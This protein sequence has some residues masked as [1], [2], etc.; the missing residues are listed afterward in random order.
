[1]E[2]TPR[3]QTIST[4]LQRI[5]EQARNYPETTFTT[6]AHLIDVEWLREAYQRTNKA[7]AAGLDGVTARGYAQHLEENLQDLYGRLRSGSYRA[8]PVVRVW[9]DKDEGK[10]RPIGKPVLEDKIVQ[11][12]VAMQLEAIYEQDFYDFSYGFRP[13]RNPHQALQELKEQCWKKNVNWIVDADVSGFFDSLDHKHLIDILRMRVSDGGII[14]LIGKWLNAGVMEGDILTY[15]EKG[16]PQGGVI[17]PILANVYLHHVLDE[18]FVREV[19]P[20]LKG[21]ACLIRYADDF[22]IGCELEADAQRIMEV[23]PKRCHRFGLTIHP[24]KTKLVRFGKPSRE[25]RADPRNGTFDFLGFTHYWALSRQG[26]WIIK[27]KTAKKRLRRT[28]KTFWQWCRDNRQRPIQ[29]QYNLLRAK[30]QG[31]YQYYGIRHNYRAL[32]VVRDYV[33]RAWRYWLSR[34]TRSGRISERVKHLLE[35]VFEL[36]KPR[37]IHAI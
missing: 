14:R 26:N 3:S 11:R 35:E 2:D 34:R 28:L 1:M 31:Y 18:W 4:K 9:I 7:S 23:L 20:R 32:A 19:L 17:S 29:E 5:A 8:T 25:T 16:T 10:Q 27:W 22:V 36:P 37:I 33:G 24:T 6:L 13:G 30:L 21:R 15:A 12:A